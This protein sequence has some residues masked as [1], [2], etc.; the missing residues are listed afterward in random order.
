VR[1]AAGWLAITAR[2]LIAL[3]KN[4]LI[5]AG[6]TFQRFDQQGGDKLLIIAVAGE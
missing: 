5:R 3:R 6:D 4:F 1:Q 2:R